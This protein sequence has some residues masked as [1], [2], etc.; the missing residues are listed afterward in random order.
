[1]VECDRPPNCGVHSRSERKGAQGGFLTAH[2]GVIEPYP[3]G[4]T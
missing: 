4:T 1:V 3:L 2:R